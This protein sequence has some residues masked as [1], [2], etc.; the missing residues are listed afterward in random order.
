MNFVCMCCNTYHQC[1]YLFRIYMLKNVSG[2]GE[3]VRYGR[4]ERFSKPTFYV[5]KTLEGLSDPYYLKKTTPPTFTPPKIIYIYLSRTN[6]FFFLFG[7]LQGLLYDISVKG[8]VT[9]MLNQ[10]K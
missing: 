6:I 10:I 9:H 3:C 2:I 1:S 4:S 7:F 8:Q 5:F